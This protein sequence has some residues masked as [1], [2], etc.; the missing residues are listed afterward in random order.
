MG[1][2]TLNTGDVLPDLLYCGIQFA[3][4]ATGDIDVCPFCDKKLCG[5]EADARAS[6]CDDSNFSGKLVHSGF[7]LIGSQQLVFLA[8]DD[9]LRMVGEEITLPTANP[10]PCMKLSPHTAPQCTVNCD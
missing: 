1:D 8:L 4:M 5:G 7:L 10:E 2:I 9:G 3:L 6:A